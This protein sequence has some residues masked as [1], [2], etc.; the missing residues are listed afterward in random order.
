M[1]CGSCALSGTEGRSKEHMNSNP[2]D[3]VADGSGVVST[4][5]GH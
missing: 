5:D 3:F 4:D 2:E 1:T